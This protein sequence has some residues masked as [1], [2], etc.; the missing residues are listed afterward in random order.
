MVSREGYT[1]VDK[2][3]TQRRG[4][5]EGEDE[6]TLAK[7]QSSQRS[8]ERPDSALVFLQPRRRAAAR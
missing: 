8:H 4:G 6:Q 1:S 5:A 2:I 3:L 7:T